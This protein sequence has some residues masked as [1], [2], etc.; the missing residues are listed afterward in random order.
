M[1]DFEK[2]LSKV[3]EPHQVALQWFATHAGQERPWPGSLPGGT[4]LASKA[5]G[6]YK[7]GWTKYA[8]SV[9]ESL[10]GP[11]SDRDPELPP[12]GTWSYD[13]YQERT[14]IQTSGTR[15]TRTW[16]WSSVW[17]MVFRLA[18]SARLRDGLPRAIGYSG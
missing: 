5:K 8:L 1:L 17:R 9:R 11:Y 18:S 15:S 7:L 10:G 4:L 12:D 16:D 6:I 3:T 14:S 2:T 13:Y